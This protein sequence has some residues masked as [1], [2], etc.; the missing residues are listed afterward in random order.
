MPGRLLAAELLEPAWKKKNRQ[1]LQAKEQRGL[2]SSS[3]RISPVSGHDRGTH[4]LYRQSY[5]HSPSHPRPPNTTM[6]S[7]AR[8]K[9]GVLRQMMA[10]GKRFL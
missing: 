1:Q 10:W 5:V 8:A 9:P 2:E 3:V 7:L 4:T 6:S